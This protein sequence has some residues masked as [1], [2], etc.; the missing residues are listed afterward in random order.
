[1]AFLL[2]GSASQLFVSSSTYPTRTTQKTP[3]Q[4]GFG[5]PTVASRRADR[6][7]A[8]LGFCSGHWWIW[9]PIFGW[10][11]HQQNSKT[12]WFLWWISGW[13]GMAVRCFESRA[14]RSTTTWSGP[15]LDFKLQPLGSTNMSANPPQIGWKI[16]MFETAQ[17]SI[18][19]WKQFFLGRS[20]RCYLFWDLSDRCIQ[21]DTCFKAKLEIDQ[22]IYR[23]YQPMG[24][25]KKWCSKFGHQ[26]EVT[27][28]AM[29]HLVQWWSCLSD[30]PRSRV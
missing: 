25:F 8:L 7:I 26:S 14:P 28:T 15:T 27:N 11:R 30:Q 6:K 29:D 23:I 21:R 19:E 10:P 9:G 20:Q 24:C 17:I 18:G 5:I 1:M 12:W 16:D 13:F 3:S 2:G 4:K 22:N